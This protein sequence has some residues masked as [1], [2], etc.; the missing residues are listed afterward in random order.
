MSEAGTPLLAVE[1]H[2]KIQEKG[3]GPSS[4]YS[5]TG[6]WLVPVFPE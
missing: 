4:N 6:D 1:K 2:L 5:R 3:L